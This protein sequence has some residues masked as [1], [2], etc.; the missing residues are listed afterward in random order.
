[1]HWSSVSIV[2]VAGKTKMVSLPVPKIFS[3]FSRLTLAF[4]SF[5]AF[6]SFAD[7]VGLGAF[8]VF[9]G[10]TVMGLSFEGVTGL[11]F[12]DATVTGLHSEGATVM[13]LGFEGATG[14]DFEGATVTGFGSPSFVIS[15]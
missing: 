10:A 14:L 1:M 11:D 15:A 5:A 4:A 3:M 7:F 12:E 9:E 8:T 13:G 2:S 6:D